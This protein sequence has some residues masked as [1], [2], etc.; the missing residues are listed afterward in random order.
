MVPEGRG[1]I[2]E[3]IYWEKCFYIHVIVYVGKI[4]R[5]IEPEKIKFK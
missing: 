3:I 1:H 5:T 4:L 2:G